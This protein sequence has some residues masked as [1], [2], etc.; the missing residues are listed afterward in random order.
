MK[1]QKLIADFEF[2]FQLF[3]IISPS[4]EHKLAWEL[5]RALGINFIKQ[6]DIVIKF[7][8]NKNLIISNFLFEKEESNLRL[9]KNKAVETTSGNLLY[10]LPE[11]K[12]FDFLIIVAGFEQTFESKKILSM[13]GRVSVIQNILG[14]DVEK[15]KSKENLLF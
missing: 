4:S 8:Q 1:M 11:V 2:D 5:N 3:G 13:L 6:P 7:L 15:L 12:Q 10:L 9:L 14:L